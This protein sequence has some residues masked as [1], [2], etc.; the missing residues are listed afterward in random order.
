MYVVVGGEMTTGW[1]MGSVGQ[2][3][4]GGKGFL[5]S[6]AS[7]GDKTA[8]RGVHVSSH[9][10]TWPVSCMPSPATKQKSYPG[11]EKQ[12]GGRMK[13]LFSHTI[14]LIQTGSCGAWLLSGMQVRL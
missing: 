3:H 9:S 10:G 13:P 14:V 6:P 8:T 5:N 4:N 7:L 1:G 2:G 11:S 12:Y